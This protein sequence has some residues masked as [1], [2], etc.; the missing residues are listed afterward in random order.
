MAKIGDFA[1]ARFDD[2]EV[3]C[4][5]IGRVESDPNEQEIICW[6]Q[7]KSGKFVVNRERLPKGRLK[8]T[9]LNLTHID[10]KV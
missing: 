4:L 2:C 3:P 6:S 9:G 7:N 8:S 10:A 5:I 1:I